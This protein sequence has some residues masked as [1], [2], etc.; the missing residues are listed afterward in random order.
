MKI[1][2]QWLQEY[3]DG[4]IS[5]E[6]L[7]QLLNRLGLGVE[8]QYEIQNDT[9]FEVEVTP[10]R[11]DCLSYIGCARDI[12]AV[13]NKPLKTPSVKAIKFPPRKTDINLEDKKDCSR[14]I[15]VIINNLSIKD[16]PAW[17]SQKLHSIGARSI[18]S[19][20]D[21]TNFCLMEWGQPLHAF[22]YDKLIGGKIV[23]RRAKAGEKIV[24][25]DAVER[26]LDPSVL[27][28]ADARRPVAIAGIMGGKETE[29]SA[30]T[31]NILLESAYFDPILIR[32]SSRKL[33]LSSDS[34]YRFERGV[35]FSTVETGALR[36]LQ[37][38]AKN[39]GGKIAAFND[40]KAGPV[41]KT[42]PM[43]KISADEIANRLGGEIPAARIKTILQKLGCR[44]A[45]AGK[46]F[47]ITPPS[48]RADLKQ[49]VDLIEEVARVYGY[50][51]LPSSLPMLRA[52]SIPHS[53]ARDRKKI[54]AQTLLGLGFDEAI[55]FS[56]VSRS[57]LEKTLIPI[58]GTVKIQNPLSKEQEILRPSLLPSLLAVLQTNLNRGQRTI[59]IFEL[60][61]R[62]LPT[63]ERETLGILATGARQQDWRE[64]P[65]REIDFFDMKGALE[66]VL[67]ALRI[68]APQFAADTIP[69]LHNGL[70]AQVKMGA[71][72][73][74]I[75]GKV[76]PKVLSHWDI[77][78]RDV[79]F[80][81]LDLGK[82]FQQIQPP[83]RFQPLPEFPAVVRDVSLAVRKDIPFSR[84]EE[85]IA[86]QKV[87]F[88]HAVHFLE[89]YIGEK[90]PAG[91]RGIVFS[92]VYQSAR[93]TL[94][95]EEVTAAHEKIC[96]ELIDRLGAVRR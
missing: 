25:I 14:Y 3:V 76:S 68:Q 88:L 9:M 46:Q 11:P 12:A 40:I 66:C 22:D 64:S 62:Y 63:G 67:Q 70:A 34:S 7:G 21:I 10:N 20:V 71:E 75:V 81:G 92:L 89:E 31:K 73:V 83:G 18:N 44:A 4:K 35:D 42:P 57:D 61:K 77:K 82:V 1:S 54:V 69:F 79:Y 58:D 91:Q 45:A 8:K 30:Q 60:G 78:H 85:L 86:Q 2:L 94:R 26:I 32:L 6:R 36:A 19:V 24:T 13:S 39:A 16:S 51:K 5:P 38:I 37:L 43:I 33:G 95:E 84:V 74:G 96:R 29:V 90:I 23:V 93:R 87:E 72:A 53:P 80:V 15:G 17:L 48:F 52:S 65:K 28:I 27:V 59:R 41:A 47:K 55:T 49:P 56:M 50:D